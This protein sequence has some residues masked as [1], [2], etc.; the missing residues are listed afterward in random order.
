MP[1]IPYVD[2]DAAPPGVR[3]VFEQLPV[4]LNIFR[5]MAHAQTNFRP[6]MRLG[7]SIL[8]QQKLDGALR[9]LA[10]LRVAKLSCAPYEWIQHV[11]IAL[12]A[13]A[14]REQVDA[15]DRGEA[16]APYFNE[17]ESAL[18]RFTDEVVQDVRASDTTFADLASHLSTQEIVE[19]VLAIGFYMTMARLMETADID[20]EPAVG[21]A[22]IEAIASR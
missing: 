22:I 1:R 2:P 18:L 11:P 15:L 5:V 13:G 16:D 6:L 10:I 19:L 12:A 9:E 20:L 17:R 7:A 4:R 3:E 21:N 14:T 8:S